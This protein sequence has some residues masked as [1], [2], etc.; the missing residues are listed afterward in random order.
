MVSAL[1]V[2]A[3]IVCYDGSPLVPEP[4][5]LWNLVDKIGFV[6][7]YFHIYETK[8]IINICHI[9]VVP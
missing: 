4:N 9:L 5:V 7:L 2:G 1:A 6:L 3:A 8:S